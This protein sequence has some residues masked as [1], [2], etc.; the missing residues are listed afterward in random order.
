[1]ECIF[2]YLYI[3]TDIS[4]D[5][6]GKSSQ[7]I[8]RLSKK[9]NSSREK[10]PNMCFHVA[11]SLYLTCGYSIIDMMKKAMCINSWPHYTMNTHEMSCY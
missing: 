10:S 1:M 9:D 3:I 11:A 6:F 4:S 2:I 7:F 5:L 8:N